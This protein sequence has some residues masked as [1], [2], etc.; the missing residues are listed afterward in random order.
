MTPGQRGRPSTS[1]RPPGV[2]GYSDDDAALTAAGEDAAG[3]Q[4]AV[5]RATARAIAARLAILPPPASRLVRRTVGELVTVP[6]RGRADDIDLDRTLDVLAE[7]RPLTS[8]DIF[9]RERRRRRRAIVLAVDVS[10]SMRGERLRTAAATVGALTSEL[11]REDFAVVAFWSDA[12]MLLRFGET[13]SL[14]DVVDQM[15]ALT[16]SG[17]TNVGFSLEVAE[18]ELRYRASSQQRVI[19]LS[20]CVHNAGPDP[21]GIVPRLPRLGHPVLT[22]P[23]SRISRWPTISPAGAGDSSRLCEGTAMWPRR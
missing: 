22:H 11:V 4:A 23:A 16:A 7:R 20:D 13:S 10:G 18:R 6:N 9:V 3:E 2:T 15:L 21:R 12:A 5:V 8:E 19:L 14:E 1:E 17:L